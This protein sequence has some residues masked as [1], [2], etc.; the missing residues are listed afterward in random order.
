MDKKKYNNNNKNSNNDNA[1]DCNAAY[2][3]CTIRSIQV[4]YTIQILHS[5]LL[6]YYLRRNNA[7]AFKKKTQHQFN[8]GDFSRIR[9]YNNNNNVLLAKLLRAYIEFVHLRALYVPR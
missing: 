2:T 4:Y 5:I 8:R 3:Q 9:Q 1:Y 7:F 6:F